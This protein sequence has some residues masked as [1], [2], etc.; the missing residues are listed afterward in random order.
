MM[1][2]Y[3][4]QMTDRIVVCGRRNG[5]W[6][7]GFNWLH[8]CGVGQGNIRLHVSKDRVHGVFGS[9]EETFVFTSCVLCS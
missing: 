6:R 8:I 1:L 2:S 4:S 7:T 5:W 9:S 3:D